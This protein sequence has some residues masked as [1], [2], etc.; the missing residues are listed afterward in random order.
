CKPPAAGN[1]LESEAIA[2]LAKPR[3]AA[4]YLL[5]HEAG[6][7][8]GDVAR[9]TGRRRQTVHRATQEVAVAVGHDEQ[10]ASLIRRA[11]RLLGSPHPN[12]WAYDP[13]P[14]SRSVGLLLGLRRRA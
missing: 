4:L 9:L 8:A 12:G 11:Q 3:A 1:A 5:R 13:P 14:W 6:L 2:H 10:L 7:R